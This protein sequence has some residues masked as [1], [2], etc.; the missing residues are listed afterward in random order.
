MKVRV[1]GIHSHLSVKWPSMMVAI[2]CGH[3]PTSLRK[4]HTPSLA[5]K[6]SASEALWMWS[7]VCTPRAT[8]ITLRR[9]RRME[10]SSDWKDWVYMS[11]EL[12]LYTMGFRHSRNLP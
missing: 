8:V 11:A 12:Y 3:T 9:R 10:E 2:S 7:A 1:N 4:D 5:D 6:E